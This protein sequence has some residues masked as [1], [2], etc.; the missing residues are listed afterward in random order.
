MPRAYNLSSL[1]PGA[2]FDREAFVSSIDAQRRVRGLSWRQVAKEAGVS[3]ST[4]TRINQGKRPDADTLASLLAWSGL[5]VE[6]FVATR[7]GANPETL[8][9]ISAYLHSDPRLTPSAVQ[10]LQRLIEAAYAGF[11]RAP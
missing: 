2:A 5:P 10:H 7:R 4:L 9:I 8:A 1:A 6:T 3:A 11:S